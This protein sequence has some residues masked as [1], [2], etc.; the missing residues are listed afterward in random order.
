MIN[1]VVT[2]NMMKLEA[3]LPMFTF[4]PIGFVK[5]P[6]TE[7]SKI[8]RGCGAKH[9]AEGV[10]NISPEF[11]MGLTDIEGF[12][13]LFVIW[14][15]DRSQVAS[16]VLVFEEGNAAVEPQS[17]HHSI[18]KTRRTLFDF[19]NSEDKEWTADYVASRL[20]TRVSR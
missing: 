15:F 1:G 14:E 9:D 11:E 2:A 17:F 18:T 3:M 8:P 20:D 10:L 5:S 6:F 7:T 16:Q 12:S 19:I 4:S 13:H